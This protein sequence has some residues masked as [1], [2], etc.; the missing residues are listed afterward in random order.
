[1]TSGVNE[2]APALELWSQSLAHEFDMLAGSLLA[3]TTV[4]EVLRG[5]V[6]AGAALVPD[7]DLVSI[8]MREPSGHY[9]TPLRSDALA[10]QLDQLQYIHKEGPCVDATQT[11]GPGIVEVADLDNTALWPLWAPA[12]ADLGVRSVLAVGLAPAGRSA[13]LGALNF[14]AFHADKLNG[15][16]RDMVVLLASHA[17]VALAATNAI[18]AAELEAAHLRTALTTRDV[19]GQAKG[20]LMQRRGI[21]SDEA[22]D[23]LRRASQQL[24]IKLAA[25]AQ[26]LASRHADLLEP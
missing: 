25:V 12:A 3:G 4:A 21:S 26:L 17:T 5:I 20:I 14:Y 2:P 7:A 6:A 9:T 11:P 16:D 10:E 8:T 13:R 23:I 22:F 19:I 15:L 18:T 24:N 1:M